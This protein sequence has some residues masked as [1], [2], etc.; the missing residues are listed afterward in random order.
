MEILKHGDPERIKKIRKFECNQCGCEWL[1]DRTEYC[2]SGMQYNIQHIACECP[3]C[4]NL[5]IMEDK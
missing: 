4:H 3:E 1:A 2:F 5:V